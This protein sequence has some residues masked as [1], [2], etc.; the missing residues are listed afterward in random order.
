[1]LVLSG[2]SQHGLRDLV[3]DLDSYQRGIATRLARAGF[4]TAAVE[5][6]DSG[7]LSRTRGTGSDEDL[8]AAL[9]LGLGTTTRA[10]QL[11]AALAA[12]DLLA[13]HPRVDPSRIGATGVSLGGWLAL[14]TALLDDR[15]GAV[16]D[17]G[18][19]TRT[20]TSEPVD[21]C[22]A[23]P[24]L[25]ALGDRNLFQL[26]YAPRPLLAGHGRMD[27]ASAHDGPVHF[28]RPLRAQYQALGHGARLQYL[29]HDGG[30]T[31]PDRAV[32]DYFRRELSGGS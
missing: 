6:V 26:A 25:L 27:A 8:V 17:F 20:L 19:K 5:K 9:H 14:Q 31:M 13:R 18:R 12:T 11:K 23:L 3:L 21:W 29:V 10:L 4:V 15:I 1:V 22:H 28:E 7:T 16:A 32:I 2:H 24:G 30:D